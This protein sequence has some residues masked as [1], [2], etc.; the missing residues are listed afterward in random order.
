[1]Q[2][3]VP[4]AVSDSVVRSIVELWYP[5]L[6]QHRLL[7]GAL[8]NPLIRGRARWRGTLE[9]GL[10]GMGANHD[11]VR[12][13]E[14][15]LMQMAQPD[16]WCAMPWGAEDA[17]PMYPV[18]AAAIPITSQSADGVIALTNL[19][20]LQAGDW[21]AY[22]GTNSVHNVSE[23]IGLTSCRTTPRVEVDGD[24]PGVLAPA[25]TMRMRAAPDTSIASSRTLGF[26]GPWVLAWE[27]YLDG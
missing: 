24:A 17:I 23:I 4:A 10:R 27:E 15:F 14:R 18:P 25:L 19:T 11:L 26:G 16:T 9:F 2:I 22:S 13:I 20:G 21:V 6:I 8:D 7:S 12:D 1:M 3:I 5:G